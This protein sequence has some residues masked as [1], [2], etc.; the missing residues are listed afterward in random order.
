MATYDLRPLSLGE[1]LDT[2]FAVYRRAFGT[3]MSLGI[4][5]IGVPFVLLMAITLSGQGAA[6][7]VLA[8]GLDLVYL[9]GAILLEGAIVCA[10]SDAYLGRAPSTAGALRTAWGSL[11]GV[12]AAGL[13][14]NILIGFAAIFLIVPGVIVACGLSVTIPA[15]VLEPETL[16]TDALGR[17]WALTKGFRWTAFLLFLMLFAL[18]MV[19]WI[20]AA[21][22]G[23]AFGAFLLPFFLGSAVVLQVLIAPGAIC[24]FTLF[25]YDLRVRKEAFDLDR[26]AQDLGMAPD[27]AST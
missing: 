19:P 17:S 16:G 23:A 21:V 9:L 7:G 26:L 13:V 22:L 11:G 3:L 2:A 24:A 1:I 8:F 5:C 27:A 6:L 14:R 10:V 20:A 15:V 12:F 25:Y 4:I 18:Y